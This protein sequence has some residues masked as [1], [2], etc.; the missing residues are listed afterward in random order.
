MCQA[1]IDVTIGV[2]KL[3]FKLPFVQFAFRR[4]CPKAFKGGI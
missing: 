1:K 2:L 3:N 4:L